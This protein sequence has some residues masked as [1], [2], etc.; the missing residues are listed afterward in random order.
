MLG[1]RGRVFDEIFVDGAEKRQ[2]LDDQGVK[3]LPVESS[4]FNLA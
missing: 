3:C 2:L 4:L 1:I